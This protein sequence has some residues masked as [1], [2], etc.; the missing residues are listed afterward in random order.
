[1]GMKRQ[2]EN[3]A[4]GCWKHAG[5]RL[6]ITDR[7]LCLAAEPEAIETLLAAIDEV[8][9]N[10]APGKRTLTLRPSELKRKCTTIRLVLSPRSDELQRISVD[11]A[12]EIATLEFT[13]SGLNEFRDAV[14]CWQNGGEDFG[15]GPQFGRHESALRGKKDLQSA[16]L[17]FWRRMRP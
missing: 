16:E 2:F 15:I 10:G 5:A 14:V 11:W 13:P 3:I 17:W 4:M 9:A 6:G 7:S 1:M 12:G 8:S